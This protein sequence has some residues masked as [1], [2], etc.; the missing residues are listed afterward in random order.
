MPGCRLPL[1][2]CMVLF[3]RTF[4]GELGYDMVLLLLALLFFLLSSGIY[5]V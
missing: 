1:V 5:A 2:L 4:W 3:D